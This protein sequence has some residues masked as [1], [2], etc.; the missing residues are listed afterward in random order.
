[1]RRVNR[2]DEAIAPI[3]EHHAKW[4]NESKWRLCLQVPV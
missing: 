3:R 1:M 2:A 4:Q